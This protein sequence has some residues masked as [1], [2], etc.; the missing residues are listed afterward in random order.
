MK[1][2]YVNE[3]LK[4]CHKA[5]SAVLYLSLRIGFID[6]DEMKKFDEGCLAQEPETSPEV[7]KFIEMEKLTA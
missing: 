1:K 2:E 4:V 5:C 7:D 3:A 6:A